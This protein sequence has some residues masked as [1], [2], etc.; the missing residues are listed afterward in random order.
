MTK[1]MILLL[2]AVLLIAAG[3][4]ASAL[5]VQADLV[6]LGG[7]ATAEADQVIVSTRTRELEAVKSRARGECGS[8]GCD[9][10]RSEFHRAALEA[11]IST[12]APVLACRGAV[13]QAL[14][15]WADGIDTA[16]QANDGD[17]GL[18]LLVILAR[19][20]V[21]AYGALVAC[22]ETAAPELDLPGLPAALGG[23]S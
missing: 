11:T 9:E 18:E 12:W 17:L 7:I 6:A 21:A 4:G 10:T 20:F 23:D 16:R 2:V 3:C 1:T 19:R 13:V 5:G 8:T 15:S 14:R 22:V